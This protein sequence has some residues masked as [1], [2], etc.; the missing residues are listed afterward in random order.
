MEESMWRGSHHEV[1]AYGADLL[2]EPKFENHVQLEKY[3]VFLTDLQKK[4]PLVKSDLP[5]EVLEEIDLDSYRIQHQFTQSLQLE[6]SN[7]SMEGMTA[8]GGIIKDPDE[9]EWLTKIIKVLNETYGLELGEE[10]K[11]EFERMRQNIYANEE[12]M[13]FFNTQNSK[14][15]IQDKFNEEVDNELLNFINT[16]LDFYNKLSEDRANIMFK[17]LWFNDLYDHRVRGIEKRQ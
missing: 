15:N 9:L 4:L 5:F 8:G 10:D 13:S 3:Y 16:K 2:C 7:T 14:D 6:S 11:V 1:L 12:L 17:R